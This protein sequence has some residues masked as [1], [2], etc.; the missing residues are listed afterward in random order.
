MGLPAH[1]VV[2]IFLKWTHKAIGFLYSSTSTKFSLQPIFIF[3]FKLYANFKR[4]RKPA[5]S[6]FWTIECL[7][8]CS[9]CK[10]LWQRFWRQILNSSEKLWLRNLKN[11]NDTWISISESR[12]FM[13][14]STGSAGLRTLKERI[15]K[16]L[17]N[18]IWIVP[19]W[20]EVSQYVVVGHTAIE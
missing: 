20:L 1:E 10:I 8:D 6:P 11:W 18:I 3:V 16:L 15:Y 19:L 13:S 17:N 14:K 12:V 7:F 2:F 5:Q 9:K 4:S